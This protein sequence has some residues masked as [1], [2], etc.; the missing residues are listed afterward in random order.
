MWDIHLEQIDGL[1]VDTI[2][3]EMDRLIL[4]ASL[5]PILNSQYVI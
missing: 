1:V 4:E 5:A 3:R 2:T